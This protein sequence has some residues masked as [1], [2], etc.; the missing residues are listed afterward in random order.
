VTKRKEQLCARNAVLR[1][2]NALPY[3]APPPLCPTAKDAIDNG[4]AGRAAKS[5]T[6]TTSTNFNPN[7]IIFRFGLFF[8]KKYAKIIKKLAVPY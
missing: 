3:K 7:R 5:A 1:E 2:Q 4:G 8:I 6:P